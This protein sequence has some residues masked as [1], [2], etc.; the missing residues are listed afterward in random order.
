MS[1]DK[2]DEPLN[3]ISWVGHVITVPPKNINESFLGEVLL[4]VH[5]ELE[6]LFKS[7]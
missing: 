1:K 6:L 3:I 4:I 5:A 7:V 2:A